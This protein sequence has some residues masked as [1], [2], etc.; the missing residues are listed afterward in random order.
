DPTGDDEPQ[1]RCR[2]DQSH[3]RAGPG[4]VLVEQESAGDQGR[5][6]Q[7]QEGAEEGTEPAVPL[8][9]EILMPADPA[10]E[11]AV[12]Q[13]AAFRGDGPGG[14]DDDQ[15]EAPGQGATRDVRDQLARRLDDAGFLRQ[16][17]SI[18]NVAR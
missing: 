12:G 10:T 14:E 8:A 11:D 5:Y 7:E 2:G 15:C 17:K 9:Q 1:N 18:D 4:N 6:S 13:R 3:P 16:P